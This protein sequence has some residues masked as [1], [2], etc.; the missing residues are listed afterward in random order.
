MSVNARTALLH[1]LERRKDDLA[2]TD[3]V[4][5][6]QAGRMMLLAIM[7]GVALTIFY[8]LG[9]PLR[10]THGARVSADEPFYLLTTVSLL[11]DG[12]LDLTNDYA[13]ERYHAFYDHPDALWHQSKPTADGRLPSPHNLG[14]SLLIVPAYAVGG[15]DAVKAFLAMIGAATVAATAML[16]YRFTGQTWP[17][18]IS[19]ALLGVSAPFFVY[20]S[21]VYPEMPAALCLALALL[22]LTQPSLGWRSALLLVVLLS[23]M[24][25][26]GSKYALVASI[27]GYFALL[28]FDNPGRA[29]FLGA[30]II[31][32]IAYAGFHLA[33]Y[34]GLT[35]Y[36]VNVVYFGQ[37][38]AGL[39]GAHFEFINRLYRLAGLWIDGEFG[40]I[41]WAPFLLLALPALPWLF[42]QTNGDK[43]ALAAVLAG[44]IMVAAFLSITM[45]GWWF[46]GRMLIV[47]LPVLAV[48]VAVTLARLSTA[49]WGYAITA[50]LGLY[51]LGITLALIAETAAERVVLIVDPFAMDWPPFR[52]IAGF[53]PV[54]TSYEPPTWVLTAAWAIAATV[55]VALSR[56]LFSPTKPQE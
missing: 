56:S 22:V 20:A 30:G 17:S 35:P 10:A 38:T 44:Q 47:V 18:L 21:Q 11:N 48:L 50:L 15:L 46:P 7:L 37:D 32:G 45:R 34:G 54:Y 28:R 55:L 36:G 12:D 29:A 27:A 2:H 51:G 16:A 52:L 4:E 8:Q 41:R 25:W 13:L 14:L 3:D 19:A 42:R 39:L 40:L 5:Q 6:T 9:V 24:A 49:R 23:S 53:F 43:L 26:L 1:L 33:T 31:S